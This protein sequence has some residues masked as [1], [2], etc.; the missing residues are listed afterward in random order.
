[1]SGFIKLSLCGDVMLGRGI[2]QI[3]PHPGDPRIYELHANSALFYVALA[4][5]AYGPI[6]RPVS[7]AY[8]WGDALAAL[9]EARPDLVIVNLET[10]ITKSR[11]YLPKGINYKMNPENVGCLTAAK[12]RLLC[13]CQQSRSRLGLERAF[14]DLGDAR[15]IRHPHGRCRERR[16]TSGGARHLRTG[17][18]GK[19]LGLRLRIGRQRHSRGLGGGPRQTG[20]EYSWRHLR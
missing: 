9:K 5:E 19:R 16:R 17:R 11:D 13:S 15:K 10:S 4:E 2:D 14:G 12:D 8:V 1:M 7:F 3:L 20:R 6:P 18:Q